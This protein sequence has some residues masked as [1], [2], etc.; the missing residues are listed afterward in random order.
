MYLPF[1]A[2]KDTSNVGARLTIKLGHS[3]FALS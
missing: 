2:T 1:E 3:T